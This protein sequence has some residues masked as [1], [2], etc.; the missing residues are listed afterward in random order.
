MTMLGVTA[1]SIILV[2]AIIHFIIYFWFFFFAF[3]PIIIIISPPTVI[4][5]RWVIIIIWWFVIRVRTGKTNSRR[6]ASCL[7]RLSL[8]YMNV[9][10]VRIRWWRR[11]PSCKSG[12]CLSCNRLC[13]WRSS[14]CSCLALWDR[15]CFLQ[16][17]ILA[18]PIFIAK[19]P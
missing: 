17:L 9:R 15:T 7:L 11:S 10:F 18:V 13:S 19:F 5:R 12:F 6:S 1:R 2:C 14:S 3:F 4:I 16:P 8:I